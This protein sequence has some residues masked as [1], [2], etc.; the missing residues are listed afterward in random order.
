[1]LRPSNGSQ[2]GGG[3]GR[4][5]R[6]ESGA[7]APTQEATATAGV[8]ETNEGGQPAET[9]ETGEAKQEESGEPDESATRAV[10]G[11]GGPG[12]GQAGG[13]R[14]PQ[15]RQGL[16]G[17]RPVPNGRYRV[18]LV[19]DGKELPATTISVER[20]PNV[21]PNAIADEE[22]ETRLLLDQQAAEDKYRGREKS[23]ARMRK[24]GKRIAAAAAT[25]AADSNTR[26]VDW[27]RSGCSLQEGYADRCS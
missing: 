14:P 24:Y 6:P 8:Q 21:A 4:G 19:V 7:S 9:E 13:G 16:R 1:M 5:P 11:R 3:G 18:V 26:T 15:G 17:G 23:E 22:Y 27:S 20:D 2:G 25:A 10:T 12:G